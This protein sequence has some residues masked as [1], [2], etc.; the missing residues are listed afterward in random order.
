M[1]NNQ[2]KE[3]ISDQF[4]DRIFFL[5]IFFVIVNRVVRLPIE[6]RLKVI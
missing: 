5:N 1:F 6:V 3:M 2:S 4:L